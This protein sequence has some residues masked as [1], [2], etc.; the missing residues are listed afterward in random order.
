M[1]IFLVFFWGA[2]KNRLTVTYL[3]TSEHWRHMYSQVICTTVKYMCNAKRYQANYSVKSDNST[4][5]SAMRALVSMVRDNRKCSIGENIRRQSA[6]A[7]PSCH[8]TDTSRSTRTYTNMKHKHHVRMNTVF[9]P[10]CLLW[11]CNW[12]AH[13][14]QNILWIYTK[15]YI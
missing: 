5:I 4:R 9:K 15:G 7:P 10:S 11:R 3:I 1:Q 6:D 12:I 8:T 2:L 13:L 14:I